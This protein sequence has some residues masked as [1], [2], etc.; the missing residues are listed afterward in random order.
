[1]I[2]KADRWMTGVFHVCIY[3]YNVFSG[4]AVLHL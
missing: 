2:A 1:M 4:F 3:R